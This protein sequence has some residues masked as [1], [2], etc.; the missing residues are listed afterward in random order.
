MTLYALFE[1]PGLFHAIISSSPAVG[2]A[3]DGRVGMT[4]AKA[5]VAKTASDRA[6]HTV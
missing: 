3:G 4:W 2:Y 5:V 1:R 6:A